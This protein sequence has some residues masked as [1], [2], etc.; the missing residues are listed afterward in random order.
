MGFIF[1]QAEGGVY[2]P[3]PAPWVLVMVAVGP[4]EVVRGLGVLVW[5]LYNS[6]AC[7]TKSTLKTYHFSLKYSVF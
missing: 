1:R 7:R 2:T 6:V 4:H 5:A 3:L